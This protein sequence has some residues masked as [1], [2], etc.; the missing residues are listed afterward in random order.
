MPRNVEAAGNLIGQYERRALRDGAR[1][2]NQLKHFTRLGM[3]PC[4]GRMCTMNAATLLRENADTPPGDLRQTPRAP[5]RPIEMEEL[6]GTFDYA[7]IPVP[8]PAPL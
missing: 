6:I 1:E 4:Q 3:G 2:M 7:D 5:I 8:K